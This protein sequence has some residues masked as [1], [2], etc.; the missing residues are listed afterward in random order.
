MIN[1]NLINVDPPTRINDRWLLNNQH[2]KD[3]VSGP[4]STSYKNFYDAFTQSPVCYHFQ[5]IQQSFLQVVTETVYHYP[6]TFISEKTIKPI[7]A[8]RPF[9]LIAPPGSLKNL[10]S[11]GFKTFDQ[12]WNESYD[13]IVDPEQRLLAVVDIIESICQK[14]MAD[15]QNLCIQMSDVLNFNF[16]FY[17]ND[18]RNNEI[19]RLEN[20]CLQNL[21]PR[22]DTN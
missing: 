14:S 2:L 3:L 9:V 10:K 17:I 21:K 11:I 22:Y 4:D 12:Y 6:N 15:I 13:S 20:S 7:I 1:L 5:L 18:F 19:S 8:K 16:Q